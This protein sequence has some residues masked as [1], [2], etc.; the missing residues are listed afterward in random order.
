MSS[1]ELR[2]EGDGAIPEMAEA[3]KKKKVH[4][5]EH[6]I[7]SALEGGTVGGRPSVCIA[8]P[9]PDGTWVYAQASMRLFLACAAALQVRYGDQ[10]DD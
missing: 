9:L 10:A 8:I 1:I 7:L 3:I 6:M 5:V 4:E 2:L